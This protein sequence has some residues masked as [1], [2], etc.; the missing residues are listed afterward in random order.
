[1]MKRIL[2]TL[3]FLISCTYTQAQDVTVATFNAEFLIKSKVYLKYGLSYDLK[4]ESKK[5]QKFWENDKNRS[6]KLREAAGKSASFIQKLNADILTLTEIGDREDIEVLVDELKKVGV[7]Y[8]YWEVCDCKDTYTQQHVAI[9]SKYPIEDV[10]YELPGRALYLEE[11]DGDVEG[12]TG[13]SKGMKGTIRVGEVD[14]D[15]FVFH[16]KSERGGHDSDAKRIAQASIARRAIIKQ[17]NQGRKVIV[18]GDLNAERGSPSLYRI[19]GFDDIYEELIQ[20]GNS[21][22][23]DNTDLRWT[24][25]YKGQTDQIDHILISTNVAPRSKIK[26][27][28]IETSDESISDHNPVIVR[29]GLE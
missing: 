2:H 21:V 26:T 5:V 28:I 18:T 24:Y 8:D 6:D 29:L 27:S 22:Y 7:A 20:T 23:F 15:V 19:R 1:M 25:N 9:L 17:L 12:E 10:W 16:F 11:L 13:I 14:L 4:D 3:I